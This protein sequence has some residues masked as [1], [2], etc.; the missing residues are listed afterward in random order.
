MN[1]LIIRLIIFGVLLYA[2]LKLYRMYREWARERDADQSSRRLDDGHMVRCT[3]CHVHLPEED[4]L[5]ERGE[6]FCCL[7]HKHRYLEEQ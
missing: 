5:R 4:A 3:Y 1:L 2:G 7:D 6:W